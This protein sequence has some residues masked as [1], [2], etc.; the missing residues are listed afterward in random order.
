MFVQI[1]GLHMQCLHFVATV[2]LKVRVCSRV[3]QAIPQETTLQVLW[4]SPAA[5]TSQ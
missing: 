3:Q 2:Q 4:A 5:L 1:K